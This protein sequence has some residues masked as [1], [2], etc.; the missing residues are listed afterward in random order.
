VAA[1]AGMVVW[2][3]SLELLFG[4][5]RRRGSIFP[6]RPN[7]CRAPAPLLRCC[8]GFLSLHRPKA[9]SRLDIYNESSL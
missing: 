2:S 4:G 8:E 1:E 6:S 3:N 9:S 7:G 5:L